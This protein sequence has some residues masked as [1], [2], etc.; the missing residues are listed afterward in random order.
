MQPPRMAVGLLTGAMG[1]SS[2]V[3][4]Q[5]LI[6]WPSSTSQWLKKPLS[7]ADTRRGPTRGYEKR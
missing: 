6:S 3:R 7:A 2:P 4:L 5:L 1:A